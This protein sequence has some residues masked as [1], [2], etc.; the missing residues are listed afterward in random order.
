MKPDRAILTGSETFVQLRPLQFGHGKVDRL[1]GDGIPHF[2]N[3]E[4]LIGL[5]QLGFLT[6]ELVFVHGAF[7]RRFR[8]SFCIH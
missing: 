1:F 7:R 4:H 5:F 8:K 6:I 2:L 3:V